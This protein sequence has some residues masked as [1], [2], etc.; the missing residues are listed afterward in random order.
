MKKIVFILLL[1]LPLPLWSASPTDSDLQS[2]YT[3]G[4]VCIC[5]RFDGPVCNDIVWCGTYNNW[6]VN[7]VSQL[8]HFQPVNGWDG[9]WVV[10]VDDNAGSKCGKAVQLKKDGS[11]EWKYQTGDIN[12]WEIISGAVTLE[13]NQSDESEMRNIGTNAPVI[14]ISKGWKNDICEDKKASYSGTLPVLFIN[15]TD[16]T[17]ITS[18]DDYVTGTYYLDNLGLED[19][20]SIG[21][22]ASP[23]PLQIKGRGNYTWSDFAKKPY[24][25]KLDSKAKLMGLPNNK[26]WTLLA[27]ADDHFGWMKNTAGFL[28]SEQL[29]LEWTPKQAPVE[30]VLNGD[31]IGL[32]MLTEQ[33]RV[34]KGRV[35]IVEQAD[36]CTQPDSITG[37]WLVE[38]DNY[39]EPYH[40]ELTEPSDQWHG[41]QTIWVTPKTP[42]ILSEAQH[43]Y[44]QQQMEAVNNVI[45]GDDEQALAAMVDLDQAVRFYLVQELMSDCESYHGSCYLH[46]DIGTDKAWKFGPVWDFGNSFN[47]RDMFIYDHP[48]WSQIWIGELASH[49]AFQDTLIPIW[50]H[51]RYYDATSISGLL[52]SFVS[53]I[54]AAAKADAKRWPEYNHADVQQGKSSFM[55]VFRKHVGWLS[56][57][58]GKGQPDPATRDKAIRED[59]PKVHKIMIHGHLFIVR[60]NKI[61]AL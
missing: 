25:I 21:S 50:N 29:G 3:Q 42:E 43:N 40:V 30:V 12:T 1:A 51:W 28:L 8:A 58:W 52:D 7:N 22:Q 32:Y 4:Q 15:T 55:D 6:N 26:H 17:P 5:I 9:W 24:R 18:K 59:L 33:I 2:Y 39:K 56:K 49:K 10:A 36:E 53:Q 45:Y 46:K 54:S 48:T 38:I 19:Y 13:K 14:A 23:L 47:D 11:F 20:T 27:H 61:Y 31:Y 35:N 60:N 41:T 57:Q 37:G 16:S 34:D 44:L